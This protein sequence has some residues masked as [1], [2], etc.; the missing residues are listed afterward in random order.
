MKRHRAIVVTTAQTIEGL[1]VMSLIGYFLWIT[2]HW[3]G[4]YIGCLVIQFFVIFGM[5][6]LPESPEFYFAKGRFDEAKAVLLK[7]AKINGAAIDE[8][9]IC[10]D[11][12]ATQDEN[13]SDEDDQVNEIQDISSSFA[14]KEKK[15]P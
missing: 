4:W 13:N 8:S 12:V 6:W 15:E 14:E 9:A 7:I 11:K 5:F 3:Q 1:I 2:K 10:F